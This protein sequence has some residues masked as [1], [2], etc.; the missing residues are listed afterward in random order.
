MKKLLLILLCLPRLL[1]ASF[2]ISSSIVVNAEP[3][4]DSWMPLIISFWLLVIII[5]IIIIRFVKKKIS[6]KQELKQ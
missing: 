6:K 2:P 1:Y 3:S 4:T 5:P